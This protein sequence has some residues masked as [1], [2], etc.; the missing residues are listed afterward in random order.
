MGL[1]SIR[2]ALVA[3]KVKN[4]SAKKET[5]VQFLGLEEPLEKGMATQSNILAWRIPWTVEPGELQSTRSQRVGHD[6]VTNTKTS[7]RPPRVGLVPAD[8]FV[9]ST[10]APL[11]LHQDLRRTSPGLT[12]A[13]FHPEEESGV[14]GA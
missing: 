7:T 10:P 6:R 3:Q 1:S 4:L 13:L 5:W 8:Q 11:P 2:A 12:I 9:D 14:L